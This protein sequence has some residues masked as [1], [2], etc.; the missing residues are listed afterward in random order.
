MDIMI[1]DEFFFNWYNTDDP[2][3]EADPDRTSL[4][5]FIDAVFAK[6]KLLNV[7]SNFIE[8]EDTGKEIIKKITIVVFLEKIIVS[9][10]CI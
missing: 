1:C 4:G 3:Y 5:T 2:G 10:L 9:Y 6:E 8:Y 7:I